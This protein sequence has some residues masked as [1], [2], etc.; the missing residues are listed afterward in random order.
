MNEKKFDVIIIGG[1]PAGISA[2]LW[3][4][5]LGL[6]ALLLESQGE[7]GGQLLWTF[8]EIQNHLGAEAKDGRQM[9]DHFL[10]QIEKR[11]FTKILN[12]EV[13]GIDLAAKTVTLA[14][15]G[16]FEGE[17]I[18]IATGVGRRR[19]NIEG[20]NKFQGKGIL[21][22]GKPDKDQVKDK[23]AL[24]VGGGDAAFENTQILSETASKVI[25]VHRRKEFSAR[26]EFI[27][28]AKNNPKVEILTD[29]VLNRIS[30]RKRVEEVEIKDIKTNAVNSLAVQGILVRIGVKPNSELFRNDLETDARGYLKVDQNC[31]TNVTNIFA[32]GDVANPAS[33][34]VSSAVG[35]GATAIK[36]IR[37]R[38]K[39][40]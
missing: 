7:L 23:V 27:A 9:R 13:T 11:R 14:G 1:G 29:S 38:L 16:R 39:S 15:V 25:L 4:D 21:R 8:N 24:I 34:T 12:S 40:S 10:N 37:L 30:G 19:L 36:S 17:S 5:E 35:M 31:A 22:S 32:V 28:S 26:E 6:D 33:P 2:A 20:E 18:V 3:C